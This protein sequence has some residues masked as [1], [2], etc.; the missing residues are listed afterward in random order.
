MDET[1]KKTDLAVGFPVP[2]W[3]GSSTPPR[4]GMEGQY[5]RLEV[6]DSGR[7][8]LELNEAYAADP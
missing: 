7:H 6:L 2:D 8:A 4:T 5:C 3:K 1:T